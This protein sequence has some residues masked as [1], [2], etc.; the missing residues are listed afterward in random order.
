[1]G[2]R[3]RTAGDGGRGVRPEARDG[4]ALGAL[5]V[6]TVANYVWQ[7]PYYLHFYGSHG[8][9]PGGLWVPL[10]ATGLWFAAGA[11]LYARGARGGGAVLG[12]F[13][14]VEVLFYLLHNATGA[15]GRDLV[16]GDAVLTVA[17]VLGYAATLAAAGFLLHMRR[18]ARRRREAA[19]A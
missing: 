11:V 3:W 12:S 14:V 15:A 19:R 13:L 9:A 6:V 8:R 2:K 18:R 7:V 1:M 4:R 5:V 17:S 10:V 16:S